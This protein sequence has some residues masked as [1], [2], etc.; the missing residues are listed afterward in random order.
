MIRAAI[1]GIGWWGRMLVNAV[2][3]KS[4]AIRFTAGYT[5]TRAA[6]E[7]FCAEHGIA[8]ANDLDA[9]LAAP[10]VDAIV[11]ATPH[12]QHGLQVERAAA[13]GKPVF[14]EKPF[15]LDIAS[16][17]RA[18]DAAAR[19]G[20]VLAVGYPRRF[21]PSVAELKR[22]IADGRLGVLS[23][24]Q[25]EQTAAAGVT[26]RADYWRSDPAEAPAGAMTATGVHTVDLLIHLFGRIDEVYCLSHRRVMARLEDTTAVLFSLANGMSATLYC[27]LVTAVSTRFAVF[28]T[29]GCAELWASPEL[30]FRFSPTP[31]EPHTGRHAAATPEI[32]EY[33]GFNA[34]LAELD[35]FAAAV[36]GERA[37]PIL[38]EDILHGVAVFEAIVRSAKG[39]QPV[40]VART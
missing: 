36:R 26:M 13:A 8:L 19:A 3:G 22:R 27:S 16:A 14:M 24:C 32:I 18:L 15:T 38:P 39:N 12:S 17:E 7:G 4:A 9:L 35:A 37:Y 34:L 11:F 6:A 40:T 28:G 33:K 5:R 30:Q 23:H 1:V 21:H 31:E 25:S 2:Q 20:I 29:K 10:S